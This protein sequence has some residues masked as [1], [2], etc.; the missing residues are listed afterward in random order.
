MGGNSD[1]TAAVWLVLSVTPYNRSGEPN[2]HPATQADRDVARQRPRHRG[3]RCRAEHR[4]AYRRRRP[5]A[6]VRA[7]PALAR[8]SEFPRPEPRRPLA[9]HPVRHRHLG[10]RFPVSRGHVRQADPGRQRNAERERQGEPAR[11]RPMHARPWRPE[12]PGPDDIAATSA[13]SGQPHRQRDRRA[14]GLPRV[15]RAVTGSHESAAGLRV[16]AAV[17]SA[18]AR[19]RAISIR[20]PRMRS[21]S[22]R[23]PLWSYSLVIQVLMPR[24]CAAVSSEKVR[25]TYM[26]ST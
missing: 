14:R 5:S 2:D 9:E 15:S 13:P 18:Q 24:I 10:S 25:S 16:Q 23:S 4:D 26:S 3:V 6:R 8:R 19:P 20:R 7:V 22:T 11:P 12:L 21:P 1:I 17:S